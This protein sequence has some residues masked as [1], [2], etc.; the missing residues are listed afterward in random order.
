MFRP[1]TTVRGRRW[2]FP[3][4]LY[5]DLAADRTE[6]QV[7]GPGGEAGEWVFV[8]RTLDALE[9]DGWLLSMVYD[10]RTDRSELIVVDTAHFTA[11]PVATVR[12]PV[13]VP[14]DLY[15]AWITAG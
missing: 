1:R 9:G 5:H 15:A 7:L 2:E 14:H 12:L 10:A 4:L 13:R 3:T 6:V 8:P 11:D